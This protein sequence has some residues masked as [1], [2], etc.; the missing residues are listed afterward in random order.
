MDG[1]DHNA[2][3][4]TQVGI[5]RAAASRS[6][7]EGVRTYRSVALFRA[8][9]PSRSRWMARLCTGGTRYTDM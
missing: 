4:S 1:R 8:T 9:D 2:T 3:L 5:C 7:V 6:I